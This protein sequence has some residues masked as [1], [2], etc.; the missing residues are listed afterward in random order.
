MDKLL[1]KRIITEN[2]TMMLSINFVERKIKETILIN[3]AV[4][5]VIPIWQWLLDNSN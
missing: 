4:I 5:E 2:Q 1:L 3:E